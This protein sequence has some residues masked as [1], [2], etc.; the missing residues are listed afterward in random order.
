MS[1][2]VKFNPSLAI[3]LVIVRHRQKEW[4]IAFFEACLHSPLF[5]CL[6]QLSE[7][8]IYLPCRGLRLSF[9][10]TLSTW[11]YRPRRDAHLSSVM[12]RKVWIYIPRKLGI[13]SVSWVEGLKSTFHT[14]IRIDSVLWRAAIFVMPC[15][16]KVWIY[17]LC[18]HSQFGITYHIRIRIYMVLWRAAIIVLQ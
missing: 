8:W 10:M 1:L 7:R 14:R 16:L 12:T 5:G 11:I 13:Y 15:S 6:E 9:G 17:S 18:Y 3:S 4:H 2:I